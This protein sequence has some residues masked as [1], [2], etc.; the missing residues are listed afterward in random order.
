[1]ADG[2][3]LYMCCTCMCVFVRHSYARKAK[4]VDVRRLKGDLWRK[5]DAVVVK[6]K[7]KELAPAVP[8]PGSSGSMKVDNDTVGTAESG[9]DDLENVSNIPHVRQVKFYNFEFWVYATCYT[10]HLCTNSLH[11]EHG[12]A[13]L[14]DQTE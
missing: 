7:D 5:I 4:R 10:A 14:G 2:V 8:A 12:I 6:E 1:M 11:G 3:C 9:D 13:F